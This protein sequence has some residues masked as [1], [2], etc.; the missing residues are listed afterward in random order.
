MDDRNPSSDEEEYDPT[1]RPVE[2]DEVPD[3]NS[4]SG[5]EAGSAKEDR[6]DA[7]NE[8]LNDGP[9][10]PESDESEGEDLFGGDYEQ[11]VF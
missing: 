2:D 8:L 6:Q 9:V 3:D 1:I 7:L 4:E 10:A 5:S 11:Y